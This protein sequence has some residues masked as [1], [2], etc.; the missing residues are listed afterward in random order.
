MK[1]DKT[2]ELTG[3]QDENPIIWHGTL[4]LPTSTAPRFFVACAGHEISV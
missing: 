2:S 4:P 3:L 1:N